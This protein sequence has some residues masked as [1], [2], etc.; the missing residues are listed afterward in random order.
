MEQLG[1]Y[2]VIENDTLWKSQTYKEIPPSFIS[3]NTIGQFYSKEAP[4]AL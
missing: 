3:H 2:I 1:A 4:N